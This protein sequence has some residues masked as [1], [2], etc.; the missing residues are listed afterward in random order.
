MGYTFSLGSGSISWKA[1]RSPAVALSSCEAELYAGTAA[2]QDCAWLC[3]LLAEF[4]HP[5]AAPTLWCDNTSM[6]ALT[7]NA[8]YSAR[9][10]HIEARYFYIREMVQAG[11]LQTQHVSSEDNVADIFTK[12]LDK[13]NHHR[14]ARALGVKPPPTVV[15]DSRLGGVLQKANMSLPHPKEAPTDPVCEPEQKMGR[16]VLRPAELYLAKF[17]HDPPT[18]MGHPNGHGNGHGTCERSL[19]H[20][21]VLRTKETKD[22]KATKDTKDTMDTMATMDTMDTMDTM[23]TMDRD[24]KDTK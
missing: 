19:C 6:I 13:A 22:T 12:P 17:W 16:S 7:Q 10:K 23:A 9:S 4:N 1:T 18:V 11:K 3:H 15:S 20:D 2:A 24:T 8:V 5:Q 14:L 21:Q